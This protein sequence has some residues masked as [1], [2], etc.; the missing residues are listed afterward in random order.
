MST[1]PVFCGKDCGGNA[2]PLLATIEGGKVIRVAN[3]PAGGK[4]LTG[5]SRGYNLPLEL[6]AP[7]RLLKPLV[8]VGDRGSGQFRE[9]GWDEALGTIADRLRDTQAKHGAGAVLNLGSAGQ[10]SALHC[11]QDLLSRF[12]NLSG[13]VT[14]LESN[15]SN[16]AARFSLPYVFGKE[17]SRSGFDAAT[18]RHSKMIILWGAN[19][20][21]A[22]LGTDVDRHLLEAKERGA[23]IV[24]IDP[25]RTDTI[26]RLEAQWVPCRPG[27]DTALMLA[28]L[29][30]LFTEDLADRPFMDTYA[31]GFDRLEAYVLGKTDGKPKTPRWAA[32]LCGTDEKV[33]LGFAQDYASAKPALLFPGYSIQRVYAG[34]DANRLAVALQ[35]VTGNLGQAGGS[36][37]S[38]NNRLDKPRVGTLPIPHMQG[39]ASAPVVRWPDLILEGHAGGYQSDIHA[40]YAVGSNYLNQGADIGKN[41]AAFLKTD[42]TVC[43]ELFM[44]PTARYCD[45]VLP[46]AHSLEKSD[47]GI[48]WSGNFLSYKSRAV[49][50]AGMARTDY[51]IFSELAGRMGFGPTF[52]EGR[53]EQAWLKLF[54]EQSEV[55]DAG[56]F[57]DSGVYFGKEQERVGLADF[58][59]DPTGRPLS[60]PSGKIEIA[61][62]KYET[63]T[64][65]PAIPVRQ[66]A[67]QDERYPLSLIT[68]KSKHRTHSQGAGIEEIRRRAAHALTLHPSDAASR[69]IGDGELARAFNDQGSMR[70]TVRLDPDLMPGVACLPEGVWFEMDAMGEDLAGSPNVLTSTEGTRPGIANIMH[71]VGIQV[72]PIPQAPSDSR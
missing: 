60:T 40:I 57:R 30:V 6:Y 59:A 51:D 48:P 13:G 62:G 43:H 22:R 2:C 70:I 65:F 32:D 44:T 28:V 14:V 18:M 39:Q 38:L 66:E 1:V 45:V 53:D 5:C 11:T 29:Y 55:E 8:R 19:V 33:I 61:S 69:A 27:T 67:P 58:I 3:N 35:V 64:G 9:A 72:E 15:Y 21:E 52:T 25:R 49:Q 34:E 12:L 23:R 31:V 50:P 4:Y 16:G 71:G 26:K 68:P 10:T 7:K 24:A 63:D 54:L 37:G 42:F 46:A 20:L 17:W 41:I 56:A 36:S 47:I